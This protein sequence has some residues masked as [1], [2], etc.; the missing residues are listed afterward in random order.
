M[1]LSINITGYSGKNSS[2]FQKHYKAVEFCIENR[3]SFPKETSEF[4]KGRVHDADLEDYQQ[5]YLLDIIKDG[6]VVN[7]PLHSDD[8]YKYVINTNE[9]PKEVEQIIIELK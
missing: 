3:L 1:S 8:E 5:E 4:F 9:I 6:I 7:I 2:E